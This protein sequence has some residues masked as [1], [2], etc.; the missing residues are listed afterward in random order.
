MANDFDRYRKAR[1]EQ[2]GRIQT[3]SSSPVGW[4]IVGGLALL[5]AGLWFYAY[6]GYQELAQT[7]AAKA[8]SDPQRQV[9][10]S[11]S[12]QAD[13]DPTH[14]GTLLRERKPHELGLVFLDVGQGD[15]IFI[16]TPEGRNILIDTGTGKEKAFAV[17]Q[18]QDNWNKFIRPFLKKNKIEKLDLFIVS[19]PHS[20]HMGAAPEMIRNFPID[21]IWVS[22]Y[23]NSGGGLQES[24]LKAIEKEDIPLNLPKSTDNSLF[25][26]YEGTLIEGKEHLK[27][28]PGVRMWTMRTAPEGGHHDDT[29]DASL[30]Q[31]I[32]YGENSVLLPGDTERPGE[33][34]LMKKWGTQLNVDV[35]KASHHCSK[36]SSSPEF[37]YMMKPKHSVCMVG[38][39]NTFGHPVPEVVSRLSQYGEVHSTEESGTIYMFL[40]GKDIRIIKRPDYGVAR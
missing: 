33:K 36:T 31:L 19:H 10:R 11:E 21:R 38:Y 5:V 1:K 25:Q 32:Y 37:V 29:N 35:Y 14:P 7:S 6:P 30:T 23:V 13:Y 4:A 16:Q 24:M 15:A 2:G 39:Y 18:V 17:Q 28:E 12:G 8:D 26:G 34:D 40:D 9:A 3:S 20:D 27:D 22:G